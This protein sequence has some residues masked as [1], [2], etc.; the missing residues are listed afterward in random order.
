M[1]FDMTMLLFILI[2]LIGVSPDNEIQTNFARALRWLQLSVVATYLA[3]ARAFWSNMSIKIGEKFDRL[4]VL[5]FVGKS[6]DKKH[7]IFECEC[8]CGGITLVR[9]D[10]LPNGHSKSCGCLCE[11]VRSSVHTTHGETKN[12]TR[13]SEFSAWQSMLNRCCNKSCKSYCNYG[14]RGIKVC[15]RWQESFESFLSDMGRK[16]SNKHS[17]ERKDNNGNYD[18]QNCIWATA[19]IQSRNRRSNIVIRLDGQTMVLKDWCLKL[20]LQYRTVHWRISNGWTF[21][22]A[23]EI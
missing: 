7:K 10:N 17:I 3:V 21:K 8:D 16:P 19:K 9:G 5:S 14:G 15:E 4:T 20:G 11:E 12:H 13:S 23:L 22:R 18:P 6:E 2:L 1:K